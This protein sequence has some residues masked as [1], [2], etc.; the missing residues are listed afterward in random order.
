M[1]WFVGRSQLNALSQH[2]WKHKIME[3]KQRFTWLHSFHVHR[4]S[5]AMANSLSKEDIGNS[6]GWLCNEEISSNELISSVFFCLLVNFN[7][8]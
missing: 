4:Q 8:F 5:N 1:D 3:L 2:P 6:L 7:V